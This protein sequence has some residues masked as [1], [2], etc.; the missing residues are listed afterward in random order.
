MT[1]PALLT[2]ANGVGPLEDVEEL[3]EREPEQHHD[4][5]DR[6]QDRD[7][8]VAV[9]VQP[10]VD[11]QHQTGDAD[12]TEEHEREDVLAELLHGLRPAIAQ[13]SPD[14]SITPASTRNDAHTSPWNTMNARTESTGNSPTE[15]PKMYVR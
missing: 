13:P 3:G 2:I 11:R 10:R 7:E 8:V 4:H 5:R 15:N 14:A 1:R 12:R 9:A 6:V